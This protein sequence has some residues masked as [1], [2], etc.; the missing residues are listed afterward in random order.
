MSHLPSR[1][2]SLAKPELS[3]ISPSLTQACWPGATDVDFDV[4]SVLRIAHDRLSEIESI[5]SDPKLKDVVVELVD[6]IR[7][8]V[9]VITKMKG[10]AEEMQ[11]SLTLA[12]SNLTLALS[13][14]EMLEEAL[15]RAGGGQGK[16]IGWRRW[17]DREGLKRSSA[18]AT[19]GG[20]L[21]ALPSE[22]G[23]YIDTALSQ[24]TRQNPSD[25]DVSDAELISRS[26]SPVPGQENGS[27]HPHIPVREPSAPVTTNTESRFFKFRFGGGNVSSASFFSSALSRSGSI[28]NAP[29]Q[30]SH[31]TSPSLPSLP[32]SDT[33]WKEPILEATKSPLVED[34]QRELIDERKRR[35]T[36]EAD[37]IAIEAE[38]ENLSAELFEE[39]NKMVAI[40]R[41][42]LAEVEDELENA[43]EERE[44]LKAA[45]RIVEREN[46]THGMRGVSTAKGSPSSLQTLQL[47]RGSLVEQALP[48]DVVALSLDPDPSVG[49]EKVGA[50]EQPGNSLIPRTASPSI[51]TRNADGVVVS[52]IPLSPR[53]AKQHDPEKINA[54]QDAPFASTV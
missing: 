8:L 45:L 29:P 19:L 2:D 36:A 53:A 13:N 9:G 1:S 52:A 33:T 27:L 44:A 42:K 32:S 40:E 43:R 54:A 46:M 41:R 49:A 50:Q 23:S 25:S 24:K 15:K 22:D 18:M 35:E 26:G 37:K 11:T 21:S 38:L 6:T 20:S 51:L 10:A 28:A 39:A 4:D 14:T 12:N 31:L 7:T 5:G 17:S 48:S 34:L 3:T 30:A 16:D 47:E